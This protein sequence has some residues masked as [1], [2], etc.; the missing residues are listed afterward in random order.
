MTRPTISGLFP[1]CSPAAICG[2]V[3]A[4]VVY[5]LYGQSRGPWPHVFHECGEAVP[6]VADFYPASTIAIVILVS[7]IVATVS[8]AKP[9]VIDPSPFR[10]SRKSMFEPQ[11]GG[12]LPAV[13]STT[14][15][16]TC[17][18]LVNIPQTAIPTVAETFPYYRIGLP[19]VGRMHSHKPAKSDTANVGSPVFSLS[20]R[21]GIVPSVHRQ[22]CITKPMEVQDPV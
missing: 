14:F 9:D 16:A 7:W 6:S 10:H 13:A 15:A 1:P 3:I 20:E 5:A 4:V 12:V 8:H 18:E 22:D 19:L 17:F 2:L 21:R 11:G